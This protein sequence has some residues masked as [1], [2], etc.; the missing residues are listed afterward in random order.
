MTGSQWTAYEK[1]LRMGDFLKL[2]RLRFLNPDGSTAFTV[3]NDPDNKRSGAFLRA[4]S[5]S[6]NLQNGVRRTADVSLANVDGAFDY[7]VEK[8]W[9]GSEIAV[10]MGARLQDGTELYFPQG[11]Y[12]VT[13]PAE[14]VRPNGRTVR[15]T[16]TDKWAGLDGT[17]N[18]T[19][20]SSYIVNTG[21]NIFEPIA[22]LLLT[23]RGDGQPYDREAPVFTEY[24]NGKTQAL[25]GGGTAA[26]TST[27][28]T[29]TV[30]SEEGS[31]ADV[32]LG[33]AEMLVAW[34]GYDPTGR[35]RIDPSQN[36]ILDTDK[37]VAWR[38]SLEEAQI[39]GL[40]YDVKL[41]DVKNDYIVVGMMA[42]DYSQP[43]ARAQNLDPR[44]DTNI[45]LIGRK[46]KRE[47]KP[48]YATERICADYAEWMVKRT[49]VLH[50]AVTIQCNQIFHLTEN[51]LIE[52]VR[53]DLPGA[54]VEKH[55]VQGFT[56]PLSGT[57]AMSITAT[58]IHDF[59]SITLSTWPPAEE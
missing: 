8:V 35:L 3:D 57:E 53:S 37:P 38:F 34:V 6:V 44:S 9:F 59:P 43:A 16:L 14:E 46:T 27:P 1:A 58:S 12:R 18:G 4:G 24:Y 5:V 15:Y 49:S 13:G 33:L 56:L 29:M 31:V 19:L 50:R 10:D 11:V 21:T 48:E 30:D 23:D 7:N 45:N 25:P 40:A 54:P 20:E 22:A 32:I 42:E 26:I 17:L 28:Y 41:Q 2:A 51:T 55:L 39:L 36:D 52:V 47:S